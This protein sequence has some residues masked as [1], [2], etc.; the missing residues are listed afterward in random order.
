MSPG[1]PEAPQKCWPRCLQQEGLLSLSVARLVMRFLAV[2]I[3]ESPPCTPPPVIS[4][5]LMFWRCRNA[6]RPTPA[7]QDHPSSNQ[8]SLCRQAVP[9]PRPTH[10]LCPCPFPVQPSAGGSAACRGLWKSTVSCQQCL[11]PSACGSQWGWGHRTAPARPHPHPP[12]Y[13]WYGAVGP[14]GG[15]HRAQGVW[16]SRGQ[17]DDSCV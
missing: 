11:L 3:C 17:A 5:G 8:G 7:F 15:R 1:L 9:G 6:L 4:G 14:K 13:V 12:C 16:G 10:R 2:D